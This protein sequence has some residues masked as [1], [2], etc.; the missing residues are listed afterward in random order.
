MQ[1]SNSTSAFGQPQVT[2]TFRTPGFGAPGFGQTPSASGQPAVAKPNFGGADANSGGFSA[3][4]GPVPSA[5]ATAAT[6][7][8]AGSAF[9]QSAFSGS[10]GGAQ[11]AQSAFG[12][13]NSTSTGSAF[14]RPSA[15]GSTSGAAFGQT[16]PFGATN[17][18]ASAFG[19]PTSAPASAFGQAPIV[20][21]S[22]PTAPAFGQPT[23]PTSAFGRPVAT[24]AFGQPTTQTSAF[25]SPMQPHQSAFN[26][27]VS[28]SGSTIVPKPQAKSAPPDFAN[29]KPTYKPG[30]DPYDALLPANYSSLLPDDVRAAFAASRFSWDNV[31]DWIPPLDMR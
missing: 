8:S 7:S 5:F 6:T 13:L 30:L 11:P 16:S 25:G 2:S 4:A 14:G 15:F 9:G 22:S 20:S 29:V 1:S 23:P 3:F 24:T 10:G 18:T 17:N 31:P 19:Q 12:A 28:P 27:S 21:S 26:Q